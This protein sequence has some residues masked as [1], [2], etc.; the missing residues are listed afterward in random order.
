MVKKD[1]TEERMTIAR[2]DMVERQ[3]R[4]RGIKNERVLDV[5]AD[6]PRELFV[7]PKLWDE[8]YA[9]RA[10]PI[11]LGQ[12][13]SQPLIVAIMTEALELTGS[14]KVLE[15][16]TGSG[17]QAAIL[18]QLADKILTV[19]RVRELA[20]S[21]EKL[22]EELKL[23]N[24]LVK[25][26]DGTYG[27]REEA[28]FDAIIVTAGAPAEAKTLIDQL[29]VGGRLVIPIGDRETQVLYRF[30]KEHKR[31]VKEN[32]GPVRFVPLVGHYGWDEP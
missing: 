2:A 18:A 5:M 28:P 21:A 26:G 17:Y 7:P 8:A 11:G 23:F 13:I 10:L 12:T 27:W 4:R 29:K 16:G 32:L 9:D 6:V 14:E 15:I 24:I 22:F 19:E 30:I 1:L 25:V 31:I 20:R 3:L